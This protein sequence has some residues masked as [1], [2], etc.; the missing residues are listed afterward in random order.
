MPGFLCSADGSS[1]RGASRVPLTNGPANGPHAGTNLPATTAIYRNELY[2]EVLWSP[3]GSYGLKN[4]STPTNTL[5]R[6]C[7]R[8]SVLYKVL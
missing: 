3:D 7:A 1:R 6:H 8:L 5:L 2:A 4:I